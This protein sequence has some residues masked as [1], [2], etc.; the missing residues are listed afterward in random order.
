MC[1]QVNLCPFCAL[2]LSVG[3]LNYE[4]SLPTIKVNASD[5]F[6]ALR[7]FWC[8]ILG[9]KLTAPHKPSSHNSG[10]ILEPDVE[11]GPVHLFIPL[12]MELSAFLVTW[13]RM[14]VIRQ[15]DGDCK[16]YREHCLSGPVAY[17]RQDTPSIWTGKINKETKLSEKAWKQRLFFLFLVHPMEGCPWN[18]T[19]WEL[20][21][22]WETRQG[23]LL[24][25]YKLPDPWSQA[26][27]RD[28]QK[29]IF[30]VCMFLFV[31]EEASFAKECRAKYMTVDSLG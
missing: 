8:P 23:L 2:L 18:Y 13:C 16:T 6:L 14:H 12:A 20:I 15:S 11:N 3:N 9:W 4:M 17:A 5:L 1:P 29:T 24:L 19:G 22:I 21:I 7:G 30:T 10:R 25:E 27:F 28:S 26:T 31:P